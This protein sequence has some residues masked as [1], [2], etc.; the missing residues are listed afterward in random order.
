M[1]NAASVKSRNHGI[2]LLRVILSFC[3]IMIHILHYGGFE[4]RMDSTS[5]GFYLLWV[6]GATLNCTVNCFAMIS[7]FVLYDQE[8]RYK[9]I[10]RLFLIALYHGVF[11]TALF[12]IFLPHAVTYENW[13]EAL[14]P[15]SQEEFWYFTAYV[16]AFFFAPFVIQGMRALSKK[17]AD[18]LVFALVFLFSVVPTFGASDPFQ[19]KQGYSALWLLVLLVI[20]TYLK[21]YYATF[22]LKKHVLIGIFAGSV[23][24]TCLGMVLSE[25]YPRFSGIHLLEYTSPTMVLAAISA[26]LLFS[27][28]SVPNVIKKVSNFCVPFSFGIYLIHEH[29]L[30][31]ENLIKGKFLSDVSTSAISKLITVLLGTLVIWLGC[32]VLEFVRR[33]VFRLLC[34]ERAIER[35]EQRLID[36][37]EDLQS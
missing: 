37:N 23:L 29:P 12:R 1:Q 6:I 19:L 32:F 17:Q 30:V 31:R 20:G 9:N 14:F 35:V 2:D 25:M 4:E 16:G 3:V 27:S 10:F 8:I 36:D 24:V 5:G 26:V 22:Q 11:I 33:L 21:K 34:V 18:T 13:I 28:L 7:G 15:V